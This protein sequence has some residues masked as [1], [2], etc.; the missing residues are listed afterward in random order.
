MFG[1]IYRKDSFAY[2]AVGGLIEGLQNINGVQYE[3]RCTTDPLKAN[4]AWQ[5]GLPQL[6]VPGIAN[7]TFVESAPVP[8]D[9]RLVASHPNLNF[10]SISIFKN[11]MYAVVDPLGNGALM[12]VSESATPNIPAVLACGWKTLPKLLQVEL[13][14]FTSLVLDYKPA[15]VYP[16]LTA[17]TTL[18]TVQGMSE[19]T[20]D[21]ATIHPQTLRYY[22]T[23]ILGE[24]GPSYSLSVNSTTE[25]VLETIL[26]D[27]GKAGMT[28][29]NAMLNMLTAQSAGLITECESDNKTVASHWRF[30]NN[31]RLGWIAVVVTIAMGIVGIATAIWMSRKER[32]HGVSVLSTAGGF[33][34]ARGQDIA[35]DQPL[36]IRDGK[37]VD[38][39]RVDHKF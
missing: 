12:T 39:D 35:D 16:Y 2:G 26:A 21:G 4:E 19:A 7:N 33:I 32:L 24:A 34:L 27:G 22:R 13:V 17:R 11:A 9:F 18:M 10:E 29:W 8:R 14:N 3:A 20:R 28:R 37:V 25:Q 30:G 6:S 5:S 23:D 1:R 36:V 15:E 38:V 31:R